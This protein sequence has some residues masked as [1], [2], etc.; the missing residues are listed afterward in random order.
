M[1]PYSPIAA[2]FDVIFAFLSFPG[3]IFAAIVWPGVWA[4]AHSQNPKA[5]MLAVEVVNNVFY[6]GLFIL[7]FWLHKKWAKTVLVQGLS[8]GRKRLIWRRK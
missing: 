5:V 7:I 1:T 2:F 6:V 4:A 8:L 3:I